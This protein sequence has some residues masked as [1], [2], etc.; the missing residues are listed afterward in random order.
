MYFP[1]ITT[2]HRLLLY[3]KDTLRS[4]SVVKVGPSMWGIEE[5]PEPQLATPKWVLSEWGLNGPSLPSLTLFLVF[6]H[7]SRRQKSPRFE[8]DGENFLFFKGGPCYTP[9][10]IFSRAGSSSRVPTINRRSRSSVVCR[11][12]RGVPMRP[13][14]L[15]RTGSRW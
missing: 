3:V 8:Y 11:D 6:T 13:V 5:R 7:P 1:S 9:P 14:V 10:R 12:R 4:P 2:V 15:S